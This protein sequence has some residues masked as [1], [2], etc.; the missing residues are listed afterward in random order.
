L[1]WVI[2][3]SGTANGNAEAFSL[4]SLPKLADAK[5]QQPQKDKEKEEGTSSNGGKPVTLLHYLIQFVDKKFP[6]V[7]EWTKEL[8]AVKYATKLTWDGIVDDVSE[9]RRG[10][11][12]TEEKMSKVQKSESRWDVFDK[13]MPAGIEECRKQFEELDKLYVRITEDFKDLV[14]AYGDDPVTSKPEEFFGVINDFL[15]QYEDIAKEM[16]LQALKEEKE[17]KKR[18][19]EEKKEQ[20][21]KEL[22]ERKQ[23]VEGMKNTGASTARVPS[24]AVRQTAAARVAPNTARPAPSQTNNGKE[25]PEEEEEEMDGEEEDGDEDDLMDN[26]LSSIK[27][28]RSFQKRRLRRQDTLR[29]KRQQAADAGEQES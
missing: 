25:E 22:E 2:L 10:L 17:K 24:A 16:K 23:K 8:A 20:K 14:I 28:G 9:L 12:S 27:S 1:P 6:E 3:N 19:L 7:G 18:E 13:L 29:Q 21:R 5:A 11:K 15:V 26:A 4:R